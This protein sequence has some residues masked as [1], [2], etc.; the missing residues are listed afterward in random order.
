MS[1]AANAAE[2]H[3]DGHNFHLE[4]RQKVEILLKRSGQVEV[5]PFDTSDD[6]AG[7]SDDTDEDE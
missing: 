6:E 2:R 5:E 4:P 1:N 3:P 7:S